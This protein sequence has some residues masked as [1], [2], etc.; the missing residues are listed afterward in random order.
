MGREGLRVFKGGS[1]G[2]KGGSKGMTDNGTAVE[3]SNKIDR[4]L[5]S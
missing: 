3:S 2:A 4:F 1:Q 5:D